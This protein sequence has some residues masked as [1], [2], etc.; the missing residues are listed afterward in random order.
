MVVVR[1]EEADAGVRRW[2]SVDGDD[3][4]ARIGGVLHRTEE[5]VGGQAL[6][7]DAVRLRLGDGHEEGG[8]L[9]RVTR[10][11]RGGLDLDARVQLADGLATMGHLHE[12]VGLGLPVDETELDGVLVLGDG[13]DAADGTQG[14]ARDRHS[15][16]ATHARAMAA[17]GIDPWLHLLVLLVPARGSKRLVR[18]WFGRSGRY[19]RHL[20]SPAAR[21][22]GAGAGRGHRWRLRRG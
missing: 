9:A 14:Q 21:R 19:A 18:S 5:R 11:G 22:A 1:D 2:R 10:V 12:G 16:H 8:L 17:R 13:G 3:G 6:Q 15:Q 7:D 4:D 20:V